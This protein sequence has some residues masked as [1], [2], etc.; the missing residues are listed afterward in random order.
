MNR[1]QKGSYLAW[2]L[3]LFSE[4]ELGRCCYSTTK[5]Y[6]KEHL[7]ADGYGVSL[8]E[9]SVFERR[10]DTGARRHMITELP[11]QT[12]HARSVGGYTLNFV[13]MSPL[14]QRDEDQP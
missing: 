13:M 4:E 6:A 12:T 5:G 9:P 3:R 2:T 10:C 7:R 1:E 11:E 14:V 8:H